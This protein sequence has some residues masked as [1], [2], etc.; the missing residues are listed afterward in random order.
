MRPASVNPIGKPKLAPPASAVKE[1]DAR[2]ASW[3]RPTVDELILP[4][5]ICCMMLARCGDL[6]LGDHARLQHQATC[7]IG[8]Q[9]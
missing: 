2:S 6:R 3:S 1:R 4:C 5:R 9:R 7:C 8:D